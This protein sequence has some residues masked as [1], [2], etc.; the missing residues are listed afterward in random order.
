[1]LF[2]LKV[3]VCVSHDI[4]IYG[5]DTTDDILEELTEVYMQSGNIPIFKIYDKSQEEIY[6]SLEDIEDV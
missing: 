4:I 1:M 5:I 6:V 2:S 3:F